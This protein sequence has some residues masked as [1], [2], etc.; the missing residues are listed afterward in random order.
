M[1]AYPNLAKIPW[2]L[3]SL[4][5]GDCLYLPYL[6]IHHVRC[7]CCDSNCDFFY[8]LCPCMQVESK[9]RNMGVNVWWNLFKWVIFL[10]MLNRNWIIHS[11]CPFKW[12][13][14]TLETVLLTLMSYQS[15][16][17]S[18]TINWSGCQTQ[19]CHDWKE[20]VLQNTHAWSV[21]KWAHCMKSLWCM[22]K[23]GPWDVQ[24]N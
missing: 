12:I 13:A 7:H 3:A 4:N 20:E 19:V 14:L 23:L 5:P 11:M 15:L 9:G 6:W 1:T 21:L 10:E 2:Y 18:V 8:D 24:P 22:T 17:L 16:V